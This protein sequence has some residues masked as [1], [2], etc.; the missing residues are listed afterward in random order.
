MTITDAELPAACQWSHCF[1]DVGV[2]FTNENARRASRP[3][4]GGC[5]GIVL[6]R[7]CKSVCAWMNG[8]GA[9]A[10]SGIVTTFPDR[11]GMVCNLCFGGSR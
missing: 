2:V 5:G 8:Q 1:V 11:L 4:A 7:Q 9:V 6:A 3:E 10:G